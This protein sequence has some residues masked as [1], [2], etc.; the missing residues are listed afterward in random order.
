MNTKTTSRWLGA[1]GALVVAAGCGGQD[2]AQQPADGKT[3]VATAVE[4]ERAADAPPATAAKPVPQQRRTPPT[5]L[6][7]PEK[8]PGMVYVPAGEFLMGSA[9]DDSMVY[10]WEKPHEQPQHPVYLDAYYIDQYEVTNEKFAI[11]K[12][13]R[14]PHERSP[15]PTC[16]RV[17]VTWHEAVAYCTAQGKRLPTEAEWEKA[18][19]GAGKEVA[20]F[21]NSAWYAET[22]IDNAQPVGT[23]APNDYGL[24]DMLGNVREWTADWY[25]P[26][27]YRERVYDNPKGPAEGVRRVERGGAFFLPRRGVTPTIRY[28]HPPHFRLYFLGF[29]CAQDP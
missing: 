4:R 16:P 22:T 3:P 18:A 1:L 28:N 25:G 24:Y 12:P 10:P 8:R 6:T 14:A 9:D 13:G 27:Y 23:K 29:R 15:C 26:G 17:R 11:F 2:G 20:V 7:P 19:K 21:R 5:T